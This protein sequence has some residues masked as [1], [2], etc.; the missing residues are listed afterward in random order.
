MILACPIRILFPPLLRLLVGVVCVF[1]APS[2][3]AREFL[4][5][6]LL[7]PALFRPKHMLTIL[8]TPALLPCAFASLARSEIA[9]RRTTSTRERGVWLLNL[10]G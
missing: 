10:A 6:V 8:L 5:S 2:L 7:I 4:L 1:L 9:I 3:A